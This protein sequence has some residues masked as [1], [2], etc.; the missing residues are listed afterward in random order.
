MT[1]LGRNPFE[2]TNTLS[3]HAPEVC[4][5]QE[6]IEEQTKNSVKKRPDAVTY[7]LWLSLRPL[8]LL[9]GTFRFLMNE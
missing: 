4:S 5:S 6:P 9:V 2:H 8:S 1:H 7:L 3:P